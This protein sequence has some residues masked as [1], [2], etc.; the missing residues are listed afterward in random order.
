MHPIWKDVKSILEIIFIYSGI[1]R[2][3]VDPVSV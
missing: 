1:G 3:M 2:A